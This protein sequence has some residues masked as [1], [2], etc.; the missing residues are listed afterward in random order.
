M[1]NMNMNKKIFLFVISFFCF[2]AVNK[3]VY[4]IKSTVRY[5]ESNHKVCFTSSASNVCLSQAKL[6]CE[7]NGSE[8]E[9]NIPFSKTDT[10]DKC[11]KVSGD[12][13]YSYA[14]G[15]VT[16]PADKIGS[17]VCKFKVYTKNSRWNKEGEVAFNNQGGYDDSD[18]YN[19]LTAEEKAKNNRCSQYTTNACPSS[20]YISGSE[21][22]SVCP[23]G[24]YA[25][26]G[27]KCEDT[28]TEHVADKPC[29][30]DDIKKVFRLFG[31][32]LLIARI[33]IPLIIIIMGSL[34]IFK[35]VYGQDD[36]ALGKQLKVLVWR[37]IGGLTI[38]FLPTIVN[39][40]FEVGSDVTD[41]EDYKTCANCLLDP[42]NSQTC[43]I[44][45]D[46]TSSTS[47]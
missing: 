4:A 14:E 2:F 3:E 30:E 18:Y 28:A 26:D 43:S 20:C 33:L 44:S 34:D 36:K 31:Y 23:D 24:T 47:D 25:R 46:N 19:N 22:V 13:F 11:S 41:D 17:N 15:C 5:D 9:I 6:F 32:L 1:T 40:F 21:C 37:I 39:A 29:Q 7:L 42:L 8:Y 16:L 10:N 12:T 27:N 45:E 38:F 35:A